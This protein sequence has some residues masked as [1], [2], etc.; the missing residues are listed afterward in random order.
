MLL[1]GLHL[2]VNLFDK[3]YNIYY[4]SKYGESTPCSMVSLQINTEVFPPTCKYYHTTSYIFY[5]ILIGVDLRFKLGK[6]PQF[7]E[8]TPILHGLVAAQG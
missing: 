3:I 2:I 8:N 4:N 6:I 7:E 5:V 1:V